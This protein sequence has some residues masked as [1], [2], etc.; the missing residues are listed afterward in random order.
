MSDYSH[1][2]QDLA[3]IIGNVPINQIPIP[4][5]H[6]SG[7]YSLDRRA[8]TQNLTIEQQLKRGIRYFDL[9]P[10]EQKRRFYIHHTLGTDYH[11]ATYPEKGYPSGMDVNAL[12]DADGNDII[13]AQMRHF[14]I[15]NPSEVL[16]L[17]FQNFDSFT[18]DDG[19]GTNDYTR[20]AML[21]NAYFY[22]N[23]ATHKGVG[24]RVL[25]YNPPQTASKNAEKASLRNTFKDMTLN[26]LKKNNTRV[27]IFFA[28]D[29]VKAN[30]GKIPFDYQKANIWPTKTALGN[31]LIY[32]PYWNEKASWV[33]DDDSVSVEK[34]WFPYH[35]DNI[36]NWD[37]FGFY[38][39]QSQM[40]ELSATPPPTSSGYHSSYISEQCAE[41]TYRMEKDAQGNLISN[42]G[43]NADRYVEWMKVGMTLNVI[44]FDFVEYGGLLPKIMAMY[45]DKIR[46]YLK[47][48]LHF[49][50]PGQKP[51]KIYP[52]TMC[53]AATLKANPWYLL[54]FDL[55]KF[56]YGNDGVIR[57]I[58][59]YAPASYDF[60]T[61]IDNLDGQM[62]SFGSVLQS[63]DPLT[64]ICGHTTDGPFQ[65]GPTSPYY[66]PNINTYVKP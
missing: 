18:N 60:F 25:P 17:R 61:Y 3:P 42:N 7:T 37:V 2:M 28:S 41:Y 10:R 54:I 55:T 56:P 5:S 21:A 59:L 53:P 8:I 32:T 29:E 47:R 13:F 24:C 45:Q 34:T 62:R 39:L 46:E 44:T 65:G 11:L 63:I 38:V 30:L 9:R 52:R 35:L 27:I 19:D 51:W 14:L 36:H 66:D 50:P 64:G 12:K 15:N 49:A 26:N 57:P 16:I 33:A 58:T 1:W 43:R 22:I 40:E 31:K 4:G 20:L 23:P 48:Q 6:D